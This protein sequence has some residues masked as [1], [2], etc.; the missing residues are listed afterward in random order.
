MAASDEVVNGEAS[1]IANNQEAELEGGGAVESAAK[2]FGI[3]PWEYA[4]Y[5]LLVGGG[6]CFIL[7]WFLFAIPALALPP[8]IHS[9]YDLASYVLFLL[10]P[11]VF[12]VSLILALVSFIKRLS[13]YATV[14]LLVIPF[15]TPLPWSVVRILFY[16][17][18][19]AF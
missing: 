10:Y 8:P 19:A 1:G 2:S 13:R 9:G 7:P 3:V 5:G 14:F 16:E 18:K 15:L 6:A 4:L 17:A 11:F 12:I